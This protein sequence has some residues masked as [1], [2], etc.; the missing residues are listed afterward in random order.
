[1]FLG[2]DEA[3]FSETLPFHSQERSRTLSHGDRRKP[4][5]NFGHGNQ[6]LSTVLMSLMFL[7]LLVDQIQ[8]ACYPLFQAV[9]EKLNTRRKQWDHLRSHVRHFDFDSFADLWAAVLT[10]AA[11]N[12]CLRR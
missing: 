4:I 7:A 6:N 9:L 10:G 5:S 12:R 8:Q 3:D 11:K 2:F 1:M